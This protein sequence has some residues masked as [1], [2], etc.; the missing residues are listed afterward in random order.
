MVLNM[1]VCFGLPGYLNACSAT[2][3]LNAIDQELV[4][5]GRIRGNK[6]YGW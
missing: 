2:S 1:W 6:A 3:K 4:F 5:T